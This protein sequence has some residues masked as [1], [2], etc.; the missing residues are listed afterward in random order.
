MRDANLA[1]GSAAH[2]WG[3]LGALQPRDQRG[4]EYP[5]EAQLA[6]SRDLL[7]QRRAH[8]EDRHRAASAD[9]RRALGARHIARLAEAVAGVENADAL[10]VPLDD[11]VA[12]HQDVE[13]VVHLAFLDDLLV[14][15][16][17][18]PVARA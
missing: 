15:G 1:S 12:G 9:G 10:T 4:E 17:I 18:L 11:T 7:E 6:G 16:V 5:V 8:L 3:A 2:R 13:A 14:I